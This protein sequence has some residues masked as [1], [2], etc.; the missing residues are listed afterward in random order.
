[1]TKQVPAA[2]L[3]SAEDQ[4]YL[5]QKAGHPEMQVEGDAEAQVAR[6]LDEDTSF[7]FHG[8]QGH[9]TLLK[10]ARVRG[11]DG[12]WYAYRRQGKR[13]VKKYAGRPADLTIARLEKLA[14]ALQADPIQR[15]LTQQP[16]LLPS[17]HPQPASSTLLQQVPLL[18]PKLRPPRPTASLL[19]RERL[20]ARL[21]ESL[22]RKLTLVLA[23]A[24]FGK[25]TLVSEWIATRDPRDG[26]ALPVSWIA[27]D[28]GENDPIRFWHY[29]I[30]ACQTFHPNLGERM[31]P[32]LGA[33][34]QPPF[35]RPELSPILTELMNELACLPERG[36]LVL[37][38]YQVIK[39]SAIHQALSFFLEHQP[40]NFHLILLTRREPPLP[41]AQLRAHDDLV[42]LG[43]SHL[44]FTR[45]ETRAFLQQTLPFPFEE[46]LLEQ[47]QQR[48]EGWITGLLTLALQGQGA[49]SAQ[50][51]ERR[52]AQ[53]SGRERSILDYLVAEVL[54]AQAEPLQV[55]LLQTSGLARLTGSLCD[56]VTGREDSALMLE[57]LERANLF[58]L[59]VDESGTW[60]RYY[61]LFAEAMQHEA[62]RRLGEARRL[63]IQSQ[64][65]RW[66]EQHDLLSDAVDAA[67]AAR[68]L[69]RAAELMTRIAESQT[70]L[71]PQEWHP[72]LRWLK[73]VP[74]ELL[75]AYPT[76]S[77]IYAMVLLFTAQRRSSA[78]KPQCEHYLQM[79]EA[80]LRERGDRPRLGEVLTLHA[81]FARHIDDHATV[82]RCA[83]EALTILPDTEPFWRS[84]ALA[85]L[86]VAAL[87]AGRMSEARQ[88]MHE[89]RK[90]NPVPADN[91]Y[92]R[93]GSLLQQSYLALGAGH[94]EQAA[95]LLR[96]ILDTAGDDHED[97]GATLLLLATISY[98]WNRL[99]EA[100]QEVREAY[101]LHAEAGNERLWLQSATL[102]ARVRYAR[103]EPKEA[104]EV[105][106]R[107]SPAFAHPRWSREI[108][109]WLAHF[110][111]T[112]G[113]LIAAERRL[114]GLQTLV[115][116]D[117]TPQDIVY[118][119]EQLVTARLLIAQEE[120]GKVQ[121]A[122]SILA[123]WRA[124]AQSQARLR[125]EV[126]TLLLM[127][128]AHARLGHKQE[129]KAV[130]TEALTLAQTAEYQRLFLDEGAEMA[131]LL[132]GLVSEV[133]APLQGGFVRTLLRGFSTVH[134]SPTSTSGA[135]ESA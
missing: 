73:Q 56:A 20:L 2:L 130:L 129:A 60:Y 17:L 75:R 119:H 72:F 133:R 13:V 35:P 64:A 26:S 51:M 80:R 95:L 15:E 87:F 37:E 124:E 113:D 103:G 27:L 92:A 58:V 55:F 59:P 23:P 85:M 18:M 135:Y 120:E 46:T 7:S 32:Q 24:G 34:W 4:Q 102:L 98:E 8:Q 122:L 25:T 50:E 22:S 41:L 39:S 78:L 30:V 100:E 10:E 134:L 97:R 131:A 38:D 67:L 36:I 45:E 94:L 70:L 12:Y 108:E 19:S 126:E 128:R 86:G 66:Y 109:L 82:I 65:S 118:E 132:K 96:Q 121:Q 16:L 3:W 71:P 107:L 62:R 28:E 106:Q 21:D 43:V 6:L 53:I 47:V 61:A 48:T 116:D 9:L 11:D 81:L 90:L 74:D 1:M 104:Q 40:A 88:L 127:A 49:L 84:L 29:L 123:D 112:A 93:R 77:A 5:W 14:R 110:A 105:L 99:E 76:L 125:S 63:S 114:A 117:E 101:D 83:Q 57:Q 79:A 89:A 42:E 52:L 44:R 68:E 111:L 115:Q 31:L 33:A 91:S 69:P 54:A